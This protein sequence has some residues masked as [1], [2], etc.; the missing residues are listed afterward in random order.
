VGG[1]VGREA[2]LLAAGR[3]I[4]DGI[5]SDNE[6]RSRGGKKPL[7]PEELGFSGQDLHRARQAAIRRY[8]MLHDL[9]AA[10]DGDQ[11]GDPPED[12]TAPA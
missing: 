6:S 9:M 5:F 3:Q 10:A 4:V 11:G 8:H 12:D 1:R 7:S 2:R